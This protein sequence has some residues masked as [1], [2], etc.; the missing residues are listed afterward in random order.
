VVSFVLSELRRRKLPTEVADLAACG[1]IAPY[2]ELLGGKLVALLMASEDARRFYADRYKSQESEIASQMAGRAIVRSADLKVVTTTSLYGVASSQ[3]N[4]LRVDAVERGINRMISYCY[5]GKTKGVTV[6]HLSRRTVEIMRRLGKAEHGV[7][8]VNSVF[9]EGSSPR[10]RRI[11]QGLNLIGINDDTVLKQSVGRRVYGCE[12]FPG[13]IG[14]LTGFRP[15]KRGKGVSAA[16]ISRAWIER[17][18]CNRVL[19]G[20]VMGRVGK[21]DRDCLSK[22]FKERIMRGEIE[23]DAED[24]DP[25]LGFE[26]SQS[27][28]RKASA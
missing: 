25:Q 7:H 3:Y 14:A 11:R 8:R 17:W 12:I 9:G 15:Q 4:R 28:R 6:T 5:L 24:Q 2:N 20:E 22:A 18:L 21:L 1:A 23:A 10:T 19:N 16:S 13:A 26:F 27:K